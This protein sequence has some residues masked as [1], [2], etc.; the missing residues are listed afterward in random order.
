M[1]KKHRQ[2]IM[3]KKETVAENY[4]ICLK[5]S[6]FMLYSTFATSSVGRFLINFKPIPCSIRLKNE[7]KNEKKKTKHSILR[8][9]TKQTKFPLLSVFLPPVHPEWRVLWQQQQQQNKHPISTFVQFFRS[10]LAHSQHTQP[11]TRKHGW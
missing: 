3:T 7:A 1:K 11:H 2:E 5:F 4:V 9:V 6:D 10:S 8:P